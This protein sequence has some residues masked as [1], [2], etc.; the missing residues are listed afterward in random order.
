MTWMRWIDKPRG[1]LLVEEDI[2]FR[3]GGTWLE[4]IKNMAA[5]SSVKIGGELVES[6]LSEDCWR[7]Q[8]DEKLANENADEEVKKEKH[9]TNIVR[10]WWRKG[11]NKEERLI[12][13]NGFQGKLKP[14][15]TMQRVQDTL[16]LTGRIVRRRSKTKDE[17]RHAEDGISLKENDSCATLALED[18]EFQLISR[19][20][21]QR[22]DEMKIDGRH[23]QKHRNENKIT[24][25]TT[26][27]D[28]KGRKKRLEE[29][30]MCGGLGT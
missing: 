8:I 20:K 3:G 12:M 16:I 19:R 26:D 29:R 21:R 28:I 1:M 9:C 6:S 4:T 27:K 10:R 13:D 5:W 14:R 25:D 22:T 15:S 17:D 18:S 23:K 2:P 7:M 30:D 11:K 24:T